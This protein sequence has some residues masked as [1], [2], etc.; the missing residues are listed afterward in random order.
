MKRE[1]GKIYTGNMSD[2]QKKSHVESL[3]TRES[4]Y[5]LIA[6]IAVVAP[7]AVREYRLA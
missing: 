2:K 4:D 3:S 7:F 5:L 1:K 6:I